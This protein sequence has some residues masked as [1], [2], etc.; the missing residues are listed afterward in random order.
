M[1]KDSIT[2]IV[3]ITMLVCL[4]CSVVVSYS[5]VALRSLQEAN[6]QLERN[7]NI[8][9]AAGLLAGDSI[10]AAEIRRLFGT[11]EVRLVD[12]RTGQFTDALPADTYDQRSAQRDPQLSSALNRNEDI[13]SLKRLEHYVPIYFMQSADGEDIMVLPVRGYGLWSTLYGYLALSRKDYNTI[14]GL[15]FAEHAET[16]GLGGEVDNPKWKAQWPGKRLV[17]AEGRLRI[18]VGGTSDAGPEHL[19]DGLAGA[20]LTTRGLNNML[21]FWFSEMGYQK[22]IDNL[23]NNQV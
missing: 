18:Q 14:Y 2:Q 16:P 12:L 21:N 23:R 9:S 19:V 6:K 17:D 15:T 7:A 10:D 3:L 20:S 11:V 13:A 4:G 5:A 22:L 8:L 1:K